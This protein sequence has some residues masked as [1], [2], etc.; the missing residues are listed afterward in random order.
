MHQGMVLCAGMMYQ[1]WI[2]YPMSIYNGGCMWLHSQR[3]VSLI[4]ACIDECMVFTL[5][6]YLQQIGI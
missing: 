1:A 4:F 3:A 2:G 6:L 5:F